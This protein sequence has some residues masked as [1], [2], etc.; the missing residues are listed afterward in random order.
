[1][2]IY[3]KE[4][5]TFLLSGKSYSY[6]I[7]ISEVGI[8]HNLHYGA[9]IKKTDLA[10][11]IVKEESRQ[12][13]PCP[14]KDDI[15][16]DN[17]LNNVFSEYGFTGRGDYHEPSAIF[18]RKDGGIVSRLVYK[19]HKIVKGAPVLEG[20][21]HVR[22][23]DQ[24]LIITLKDQF[25]AM[26][27]DLYYTV[28]DDTD[29][30]ARHAVLRN[31]GKQIINL[32]KADSFC[33]CLP[34]AAYRS[35]RI[36][37]RW[38]QE[39]I[40]QINDVVHG[41][42][43]V[44]SYRGAPAHQ[45]NP[46]MSVLKSDCGEEQGECYGI[47]LCYSGSFHITIHNESPD[48]P[49]R[50]QAGV[51]APNFSWEL[52]GGASFA[53]PQA[54]LCYSCGGLGQMSRSYANFLR[55]RVIN[56]AYVY[57]TRPIVVNNWEATYFD[58][59]NE[60]L[61]PIIDAAAGLGVDT[62]VLDDGWFGKRVHDHAGLGDWFVNEERLPGGLK[63]V[64]DRCKQNGLKFGL[65]FE[66]E[67]VN[68][69]SDLFRA[70]PDWAISKAGVEPIRARNQLVLDMSRQEV[71][72]YIFDSI[73]KIL[74]NNDISY[75]KWDFNRYLSEYFT[76]GLPAHR[77]GEFLHRFV[78]GTYSLAQRLMDAFPHIFFEGCAGGG[79]RFDAGMLYYFPQYWTSDDTDGFERTKIQWGTSMC[80]PLSAMSCHVSECPNHQTHRNTPFETRGAIASLGATGYE[81]DV[82]KLTQEDREKT[83]QQV[84]NY[85][86]IAD[87]IL[88]GD[89]YRL[90]SPFNGNYFC[91][92]VVSKD[93]TQAYVVGECFRGV[94][95]AFSETIYLNG[96]AD[97]KNYYI[98]EL[99]VTAS[100]ASL[101]NAGVIAPSLPDYGSWTWHLQEVK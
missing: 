23:A 35:L 39:R 20:L 15:N 93:K 31:T 30:I 74:A 75:V 91:V 67:M 82:S 57:K 38:A 1:M 98:E 96:L 50:V 65:W 22:T 42:T 34:F 56:P 68:E 73:S 84:K 81:L 12:P 88:H 62:F 18:E 90:R 59:T 43:S 52:K 70:H 58:F 19:K 54:F 8:I 69:D 51:F 44:K 6:V 29:V 64:I 63:P 76:R 36:G 60:R 48:C 71:V 46:F 24:T 92:N 49:I 10:Y 2:I 77:Q 55:E 95:G 101:K 33:F 7:K 87:L 99:N 53:T 21:P 61:Y 85:K 78:L 14:K 16:V 13:N 26:E 97:D 80:Y 27:A 9:K 25:S 11:L 79:G 89:L 66:P 86:R 41:I 47:Q 17:T 32:K 4:L 83:V 28:S 37:G 72:D 45:N 3:N 40:P 94:P 5:R 100:G